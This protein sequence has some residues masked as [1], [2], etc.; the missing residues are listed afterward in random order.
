MEFVGGLLCLIMG[1][2]AIGVAAR[3]GPRAAWV[4]LGIAILLE[5]AV[6][7]VYMLDWGYSWVEAS[8]AT[9]AVDRNVWI[10]LPAVFAGVSVA[11]LAIWGRRFAPWSATMAAIGALLWIPTLLAVERNVD[12]SF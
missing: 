3:L 9:L 11:G 5:V 4:S 10:L 12:M 7:G 6:I 2:G 1:V 8:A